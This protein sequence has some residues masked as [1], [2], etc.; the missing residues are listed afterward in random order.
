M[1]TLSSN[2]LSQVSPVDLR[3]LLI[4]AGPCGTPQVGTTIQI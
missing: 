2:V 3:Q 4:K 1:T